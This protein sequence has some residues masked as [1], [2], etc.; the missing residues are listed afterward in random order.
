MRFYGGRG[1]RGNVTVRALEIDFVFSPA[2]VVK[3]N[4][5]DDQS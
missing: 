3:V 1:G 2:S 4:I 5:F